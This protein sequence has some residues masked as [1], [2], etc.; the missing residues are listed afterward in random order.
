M[1]NVIQHAH[2][3]PQIHPHTSWYFFLGL[4]LAFLLILSI[5]ILPTLTFPG[6]VVGPEFYRENAYR[7]YLAGEKVMYTNPV[8]LNNALVAYHAGEKVIYDANVAAMV[9]TMGEKQAMLPL[10]ALNRQDALLVYR[11]G[12]KG[13]V[14][15]LEA[16]NRE[17]ALIAYRMGEK[18]IQ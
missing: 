15:S 18:G 4:L 12:E 13:A 9:H 16:L 3:P 1:P 11:M 5:S 6:T 2:R 7:A 10:E 14:L 8:A 17:D